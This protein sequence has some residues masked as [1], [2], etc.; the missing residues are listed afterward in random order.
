MNA[1][2]H[3][4]DNTDVYDKYGKFVGVTTEYKARCTATS[5]GSVQ[6][7]KPNGEEFWYSGKVNPYL[8][9]WKLVDYN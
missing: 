4:P 8:G 2:N 3:L 1:Y 7:K 9:V 5:N 6:I